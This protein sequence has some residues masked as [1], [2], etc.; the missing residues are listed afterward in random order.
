MYTAGLVLWLCSGTT[1]AYERVYESIYED[2]PVH[3]FMEVQQREIDAIMDSDPDGVVLTPVLAH[4]LITTLTSS[5]MSKLADS[6]TLE[7]YAQMK[8]D[9]GQIIIWNREE[10]QSDIDITLIQ[11]Y[12]CMSEAFYKI[13]NI[14]YNITPLL[15][16]FNLYAV[17]TDTLDVAYI[18]LLDLVHQIIEDGLCLGVKSLQCPD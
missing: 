12:M 5:S 6:R 7:T 10:C 3:V 2:V 11:D 8:Y 15:Q 13:T 18:L 16:T 9:V 17:T 1:Y 4:E 14:T